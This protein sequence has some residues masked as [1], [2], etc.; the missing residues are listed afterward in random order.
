IGGAGNDT[1][2]GGAGADVL[3]GGSGAD[4]FV[5][6]SAPGARNVDEIVDF[7]AAQGDRIVLDNDIF[8]V[9]GP[10]GLNALKFFAAAGATSAADADDRIVLDTASGALY[11]DADGV[12]GAAA[13]QIAVIGST[14]GIG[15]A[16]FEIA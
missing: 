2:S 12:G 8:A 10:G 1:L 11:Y 6:D 4:R 3:D 16:N 13:L 5:F 14:A 7:S 15:V 9:G